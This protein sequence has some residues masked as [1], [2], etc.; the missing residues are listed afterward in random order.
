MATRSYRYIGND[1]PPDV[2]ILLPSMNTPLFPRSM[3]DT[4]IALLLDQFP[5]LRIQF[6][7]GS[8]DDDGN[9]VEGD[10]SGGGTG[11]NNNGI[12]F[13]PLC[14]AFDAE[15]AKIDLLFKQISSFNNL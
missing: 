15:A 12:D 13:K 1:Y 14:D 7:K 6:D 9:P 3:S 10:E 2:G 4:Q 11:N 5:H 8:F